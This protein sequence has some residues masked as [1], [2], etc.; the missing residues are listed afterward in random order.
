M[1]SKKTKATAF[2]MVGEF[3]EVFGHPK[4]VS[5]RP[6]EPQLAK[7]RLNLL[8]EE[9]SELVEAVGGAST[10]NQNLHDVVRRLRAAQ[11]VV[12]QAPDYEFDNQDVVEVADA[13]TDIL[14]VANG[15]GHAYGVDLDRCMVE[16]H[17]SNMSKLDPATG[18][19][20]YRDDG[21][22]MKGSDYRAPDLATVLGLTEAEAEV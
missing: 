6:A 19:P 5:P 21:K 10:K 17:S 16:V 2:E 20:I 13:L 18:K 3:H 22:V 15:A 14:Y 11:Q 1:S 4:H 8:L 12:N 7:L 9:M